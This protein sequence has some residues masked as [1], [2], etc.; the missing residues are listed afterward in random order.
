M[1]QKIQTI[2]NLVLLSLLTATA[3]GQASVG[4]N[5]MSVDTARCTAVNSGT[6][7]LGGHTGNV[8]RW[9]YSYSGGDP[10][11]PMA[12]TSTSYNYSN[13]SQQTSFRAIVQVPSNL[14]ATSGA[15]TIRVYNP[16]NG[17]TITSAA[18]VCTGQSTILTSNGR[19]GNVLQWEES[20]TNGASW[21][22]IPGSALATQLTRTITQDIQYRM[23]VKNGA[24][25]VT[26]STITSVDASTASVAGT[27]SGTDSVC[28]SG[29]TVN[30]ALAGNNGNT[31]SWEQSFA[32]SGPWNP[33]AATTSTLVRNNINQSTFYRV[34][35][36]SGACPAVYTGTHRVHVSEPT[37]AGNLTGTT[38]LC[39]DAAISLNLVNKTGK[40]EGWDI[41]SNGGTSWSPLNQTSATITLLQP[42]GTYLFH[43]TIRREVCPAAITPDL[44]I[45]VNA[46]PAVG[47]SF[48]PACAKQGLAFT[49]TTPGQNLYTWDYG[50]NSSSNTAQPVHNFQQWGDYNVRL[51]ATNDLGCTDSITQSVHVKANPVADFVV[52][53]DTVCSGDIVS[54]QNSSQ[55]DEGNIVSYIWKKGNAVFA[56]T[57]QTQLL[58][59]QPGNMP[60][61]LLVTSDLGCADSLVTQVNVHPEPVA[62]FSIEN[63]CAGTVS[64][65]QNLSQIEYGTAGYSW[66]F[67]DATTSTLTQ[68]QHAYAA[69]NSYI[70]QL[71]VRSAYGCADTVSHT[72]IIHPSP[73]IDFTVNNTCL[74]DTA[75]Y[76]STVT[77]AASPVYSWQFGDGGLSAAAG[78]DHVF[79][80]FGTYQT[81]LQV[82]SDSGCVATLS[83]NLLVHPVPVANFSMANACV[84]TLSAVVNYSQLASGTMQYAWDFAGMVASTD[85]NP[86]PVFNIPGTYTA[87]LITLTDM[88]C[89]DTIAQTFTVFDQPQVTYTFDNVCYGNTTHFEATPTVN[90]GTITGVSWDFGDNS[91]S[92][93]TDPEKTYLNEGVY[94][95]TLIATASTGCSDTASS[96]VSV[97]EAPIANFSVNNICIG[98]AAA[99]VNSSQLNLGVFTSEWQFGDMFMSDLFAPNYTYE[100]PGTYGVQLAIISD[101]G[102]KDS[103]RKPVQVYA[104]PNVQAGADVTI[105]KGYE[106]MLHATG[107]VAYTWSPSAGLDAPQIP[108]PVAQ[109][110]VTQV[111]SV[112]GEDQYGCIASDT[113]VITVNES[114]LLIPYNILTPDGNGQNDTWI[115]RNAETY[116]TNEVVILNELGN[117]VFTQKAYMNDWDGRNKTG[118][119]LPDGTYYYVITFSN[120]AQVYK[121]DLLLIRNTH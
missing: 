81:T 58:L 14:P 106:L 20:I 2:F 68:A 26:Y 43:A 100:V 45:T 85:I 4:G 62:A 89:R 63:S 121:G 65:F 70:A 57:S 88:G 109:P 22:I 48:S 74:G 114:F 19:T 105:D 21:D 54:F 76:V 94:L 42:A 102:C 86:E 119:L 9:E 108:N 79:S 84:N 80:G 71:I 51:I 115:V 8:I 98:E 93:L 52:L 69:A 7:Y 17:G 53:S 34:R 73:V 24:C 91:N 66:S 77:N 96:L 33:A 39:A 36:E 46:L 23:L 112:V 12:V 1:M 37:I 83:K 47:F 118:E 111:Y 75:F 104:L 103:I 67:G 15:I 13:L 50:D 31:L 10:W 61:Q 29:N 78:P 82:I 30:L 38:A 87:E 60:I 117:E 11:T 90:F 95:V 56:N 16:S 49:N 41:S 107:A 18:Q 101:Q 113:L 28:V 116:P 55:L 32:A 27:I 64:H 3:H 25:P 97:Y 72:V 59:I 110:F 120:A 44:Q 6:I 40:I 5:L 92:T 99:F 35:V